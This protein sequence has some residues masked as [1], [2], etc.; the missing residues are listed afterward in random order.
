MIQIPDA[1]KRVLEYSAVYWAFQTAV[2]A[3]GAHR[4]ILDRYAKPQQS[5]A[6]LDVGCGPA[7]IIEMLPE[8][9]YV[10]VDLDESY[11]ESAT[12]EFGKNASFELC[13]A[14]SIADLDSGPFD[15]ILGIGLVHHLSDEIATGFFHGASKKL[16]PGGRLVTMDGCYHP[17]ESKIG[18]TMVSNDRGEFIRASTEYERLASTA[19]SNVALDVR[20]DLLRIPYSHAVMVSSNGEPARGSG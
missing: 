16:A 14:D 2:G 9:S 17:E 15:L 3:K 1:L 5:E 4:E 19:F 7:K 20:F 18:R 10:G 11:L 12:N 6:V 13:G 8:V